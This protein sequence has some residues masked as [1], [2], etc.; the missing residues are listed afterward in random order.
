MEEEKIQNLEFKIKELESYVLKLSEQ[1]GKLVIVLNELIDKFQNAFDDLK[2]E[3][4]EI[5]SIIRQN[6]DTNKKAF[7][8]LNDKLKH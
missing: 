7:F 8:S 1:Q 3:Q 4:S 6:M 5:I 2:Q